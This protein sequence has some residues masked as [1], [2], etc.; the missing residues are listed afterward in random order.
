MQCF[1][2]RFFKLAKVIEDWAYPC[3]RGHIGKRIPECKVQ[4]CRVGSWVVDK[5]NKLQSRYVTPENNRKV[6]KQGEAV[7]NNQ[8]Y[9]MKDE[10]IE[11]FETEPSSLQCME[12]LENYLATEFVVENL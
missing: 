3:E 5:D 11:Q 2:T 1:G 9:L 7:P 8:L 12:F 10:I 4:D 6:T